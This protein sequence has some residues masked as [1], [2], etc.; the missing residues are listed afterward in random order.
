MIDSIALDEYDRLC[1]V[2]SGIVNVTD[3]I[4]LSM[5]PILISPH[6]FDNFAPMVTNA[7]RSAYFA[8]LEQH[9]S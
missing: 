8:A 6:R 7:P 1:G 2:A 9:D 3:S 5:L 4:P